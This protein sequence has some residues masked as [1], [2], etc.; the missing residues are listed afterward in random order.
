MNCARSFKT[1]QW[2]PGK[3]TTFILPVVDIEALIKKLTAI[4]SAVDPADQLKIEKQVENWKT[5]LKNY[6]AHNGGLTEMFTAD[7]K[8]FSDMLKSF[9]AFKK[10]GGIT[11]FEFKE[12]FDSFFRNKTEIRYIK[13]EKKYDAINDFNKAFSN[14]DNQCSAVVGTSNTYLRTVCSDFSSSKSDYQSLKGFLSSACNM[15][16]SPNAL[17]KNP[18]KNSVLFQGL[19][20]KG[21]FANSKDIPGGLEVQSTEDDDLM[22]FMKSKDKYLT[23]GSNAPVT[24]TW[25]STVSDSISTTAT[26]DTSISASDDDDFH[27]GGSAFVATG[28]FAQTVGSSDGFLLSLGSTSDSSHEYS[29]TVTI[30][31]DDGD[32]GRKNIF[33]ICLF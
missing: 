27:V 16:G 5:V 3:L 20:K 1:F 33:E 4:G 32:Y 8:L 6:R 12:S 17:N 25:T 28:M 10:N 7:G 30:L 26:M 23:F 21:S 22:G 14:L 15:P 19:C 2:Q 24:L 29:R 9:S 11:E 18:L 13:S 31:L